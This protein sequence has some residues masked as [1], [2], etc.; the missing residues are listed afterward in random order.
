MK[1]EPKEQNQ[2]TLLL[3]RGHL[4]VPKYNRIWLVQERERMSSL[5]LAAWKECGSPPSLPAFRNGR[6]A[7]RCIR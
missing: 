1:Q 5:L 6:A 3:R 2:I 4:H 7:V